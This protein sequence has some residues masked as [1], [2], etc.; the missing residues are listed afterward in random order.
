MS[1]MK[2]RLKVLFHKR[3]ARLEALMHCDVIHKNW[4]MRGKAIR[5]VHLEG[6]RFIKVGK[7]SNGERK[8]RRETSPA[9]LTLL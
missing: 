2:S 4:A 6:K 3:T 5:R 8:A 1:E 9:F 7:K